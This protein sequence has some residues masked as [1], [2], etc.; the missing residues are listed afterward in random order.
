M[1]S[2]GGNGSNPITGCE[3]TSWGEAKRRGEAALPAAASTKAWGW[4][5]QLDKPGGVQCPAC[6]YMPCVMA[7]E[8]ELQGGHF[9]VRWM[10][11]AGF[12]V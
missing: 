11:F 4:S 12:G 5:D 2:N 8:A 7:W 6:P 1:E 10:L 9:R 3:V